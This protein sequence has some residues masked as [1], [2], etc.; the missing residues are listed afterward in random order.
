MRSDSGRAS[1]ASVVG[2]AGAGSAA[3]ATGAGNAFATV[4]ACSVTR[5]STSRATVGYSNHTVAGTYPTRSRN[6]RNS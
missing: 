5:Y 2:A 6:G 4:S 1:G 3:G